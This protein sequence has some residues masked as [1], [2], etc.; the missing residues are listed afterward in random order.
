MHHNNLNSFIDYINKVNNQLKKEN[1]LLKVKD[2]VF[3]QK[4]IN[5]H[6]KLKIK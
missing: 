1:N 5:C 3:N 2:T 6:H 4:L